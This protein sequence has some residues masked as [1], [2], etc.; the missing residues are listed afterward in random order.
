MLTDDV[1][2]AAFQTIGEAL[3]L[4]PDEF[5]DDEKWTFLGLNRLLAKATASDLRNQGVNVVE[6]DFETFATVGEFKKF[7][8]GQKAGVSDSTL[9]MDNTSEPEDPWL[10]IPKPNVPISVILQ[11]TPETSKKTVFLF[12]D[13]SGAGTAYKSLPP[14]GVDICLVALNS[15]FLRQA[16]EF[17]C[18]IERMAK[19]WLGELQRLQPKSRPYILG[20]WSAGGYS[21]FEV[22][23]LLTQAHATV[24]R[25]ILIDSPC[26]L[27]FAALP[28]NVVQ[29]L[30]LKGLLG[31]KEPPAWMVSHFTAIVLAIDKYMPTPMLSS[32]VPAN[33]DMI[34][35][36]EGLVDNIKDSGLD[37]DPSVN[38]T[39][40]LL[41]PRDSL[42][43]EG[44]EKLLPGAEYSVNFM[45]G[46]HFQVAQPP[47]VSCPC[48]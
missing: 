5:Q 48:H 47:H 14:L 19:L 28:V 45:T 11:G 18:S 36:R 15:P 30:T 4:E 40:F 39:R 8:G 35:C 26:R 10:G 22:A 43:T 38:V 46:H 13:G 42:G 6:G 1:I 31:G 32:Q 17:T 12:P 20:G 9:P 21:A 23:K 29:Q 34:W 25:L 27:A 7:L 2:R 16:H 44:W 24:E 33:V 37:V 41:E 3:S